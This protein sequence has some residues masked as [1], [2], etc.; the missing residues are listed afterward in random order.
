MQFVILMVLLIATILTFFFCWI[1]LELLCSHSTQR[2]K[3]SAN[4][5]TDMQ[6]LP[7]AYKDIY[8]L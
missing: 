3:V 7:P 4:S 1:F 5:T 2:K 8:K 6:D